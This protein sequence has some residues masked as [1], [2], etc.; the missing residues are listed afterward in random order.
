MHKLFSMC[1]FL[2]ITM[3]IFRARRAHH[4]E[5]QI[6]SI[7]PPVTVILRWWLRNMQVLRRLLPTCTHLSHQHRITFTRGCIDTICL[8]WW[9]VTWCRST[10]CTNSANIM[11]TYFKLFCLVHKHYWIYFTNLDLWFRTFRPSCGQ[12]SSNLYRSKLYYNYLIIWLITNK[13]LLKNILCCVG[14]D[15]ASNL[16][17]LA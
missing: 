4:Q 7:Q 10:K 15:K 13:L 11:L 16:K 9:I 8:S 3:Y 2:F 6:V 1:L 12:Q 17:S 14:H 5:R